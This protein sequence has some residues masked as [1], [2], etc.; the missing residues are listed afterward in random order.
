MKASNMS[1]FKKKKKFDHLKISK[2]SIPSITNTNFNM[3]RFMW[4]GID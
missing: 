1:E 3:Q 4:T 2:K